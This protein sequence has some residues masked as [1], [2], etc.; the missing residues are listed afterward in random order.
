VKAMA[1]I[2]KTQGEQIAYLR[3]MDKAHAEQFRSFDKKLD[4]IN[5][6]LDDHEKTSQDFRIQ[7]A[8]NT[9]EITDINKE[10][11]PRAWKAIYGVYA[12]AG[13]LF[14][15]FIVAWLNR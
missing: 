7:C 1:V 14:I 12:C 3:A 10:K 8:T 5:K 9:T 4:M 13:T 15:A 11:F 6:K 2:K